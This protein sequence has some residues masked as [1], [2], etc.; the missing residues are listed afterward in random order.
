MPQWWRFNPQHPISVWLGSRAL[1]R[2]AV[3]DRASLLSELSPA[4]PVWAWRLF[5]NTA[6]DNG[7][8]ELIR[9]VVDH[10]RLDDS[11]ATAPRA[12]PV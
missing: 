9:W 2:A 8:S 6:D 11:L 4:A 3:H 7:F 10:P 12:S 5:V 1:A